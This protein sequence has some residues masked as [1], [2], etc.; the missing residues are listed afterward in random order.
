MASSDLSDDGCGG[1]A[2]ERNAQPPERGGPVFVYGLT[3]EDLAVVPPGAT[4]VSP[5]SPGAAKLEDA[6]FAGVDEVVMAAPA[7]TLERSYVLALALRALKP[8]G[9]LTAMAPKDKGGARLRKEIT[10]FGCAVEE[11]SRR[12]HRICHTVRPGTLS[13]VEAALAAGGPRVVDGLGWTQPG[14]FSWDRPDPGSELLSAA[15]PPLRGCG[16]DLGCGIGRLARAAMASPAVVR[17]DLVDLDRRAVEMARRNV[18][19]VRAGF[20][21]ADVRAPLDAG[22]LD[23]VLMNPPFHEASVED[24]GLG[25][26]FIRRSH[27]MLRPGGAVWLVANRHLPYEALL[28]TLFT[29]VALRAQNAAFKVYE[30]RR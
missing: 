25:Q 14:V 18:P 5:L 28:K 16:A 1:A 23:F 12:H 6:A 21:W 22:G 8:G 10:A 26:A 15:L 11:T 17:I 19:D 7:A 4:Q 9:A 2:A 3:H 24:R 13:G 27:Q 20:L 29:D 30:A